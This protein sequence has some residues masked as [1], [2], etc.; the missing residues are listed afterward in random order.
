MVE[1]IRYGLFG[2]FQGVLHYSPLI[3]RVALTLFACLA[4]L[5]CGYLLVL[6]H[7]CAQPRVMV[8]RW[9]KEWCTPVLIICAGLG[10]MG[11]EG[12]VG[13]GHWLEVAGVGVTRFV[14][15]IPAPNASPSSAAPVT[16]NSGVRCPGTYADMEVQGCTQ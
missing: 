15:D 16:A 9:C 1:F 7:G 2:P 4:V 6:L 12:D 11:R 5:W 8:R 10:L 3:E 14:L 13:V